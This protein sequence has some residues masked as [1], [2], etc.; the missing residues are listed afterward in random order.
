M[1]VTKTGDRGETSLL[2]GGRV[3]KIHPAVDCAG[4]IDEL[5]AWVGLAWQNEAIWN[6]E[7][8]YGPCVQDQLTQLVSEVSCSNRRRYMAENPHINDETLVVLDAK[9]A[10]LDRDFTDNPR[11]R[12]YLDLAVRVCRRAERS[13][14]ALRLWEDDQYAKTRSTILMGIPEEAEYL[15]DNIKVRPILITYLNRLGDYLWLLARQ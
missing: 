10:A 13:L 11:P 7:F 4:Q 15:K 12:S 8:D 2:Y 9:C 3:L 1:I 5:N 14:L 6:S